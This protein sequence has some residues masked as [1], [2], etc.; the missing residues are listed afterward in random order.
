VGGPIKKTTGITMTG[1][2]IFEF[3]DPWMIWAFRITDNPYVG[4]AIGIFWICLLA[5]I[6]GELCM[7]A[8]YFMNAKHFAKVNRD[9]VGHHNLS[10][11]AIQVKNKEAWKACNSIANDAFGKNFFSHIALFASSLWI[12]PFAIGWMFYRFGEVEFVVPLIGEVGPPFIFIPVYIF[13]RWGF[14]K[15]KHHI[16]LFRTIKRK[17]KE[18]EGEEE[19]MMFS[20]MVKDKQPVAEN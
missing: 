18:N 3:L 14:G 9:M 6:L 16:P 7:A 10:V 17:I 20:D 2:M 4:F 1:N 12:V 8:I 15:V 5:T 19:M 11:K 13:C